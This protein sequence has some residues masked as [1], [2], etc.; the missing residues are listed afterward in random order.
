M[1]ETNKST[2]A[3]EGDDTDQK[4]S[5]VPG[6]QGL[7]EAGERRLRES[8]DRNTKRGARASPSAPTTPGAYSATG[9]SHG[10]NTSKG[11]K[12]RRA[13]DEKV[14]AQP[15]VPGAHTALPS[16]AR[17]TQAKVA[18]RESPSERRKQSNPAA[19]ASSAVNEEEKSEDIPVEPVAIAHAVVVNEDTENQME[20]ERIENGEEKEILRR[21]LEDAMIRTEEKERRNKRCMYIFIFVVVVIIAGFGAYFGTRG[22]S[23]DNAEGGATP[24]I[25][26]QG[27]SPTAATPAPTPGPTASPTSSRCFLLETVLV[28][29]DPLHEDAKNWL[30]DDDTWVPPANDFDPDRLWN[31]RYAMAV[32]YYSTNGNGW[33]FDDGWLSSTSVCDWTQ[34]T[35]VGSDSRVT[36]IY[37]SESCLSLFLPVPQLQQICH[38]T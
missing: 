36:N 37:S 25:A 9:S 15:T 7:N 24:S 3:A 35:C 32:L 13:M 20:R 23:T 28:D 11:R 8:S 2:A 21:Q 19:D 31:E 17:R 34:V 29:H 18:A 27:D 5:S 22:S 12:D 33:T 1:E 16:A 6:A 10:S 4:R 14:A 38:L 26:D 30:C